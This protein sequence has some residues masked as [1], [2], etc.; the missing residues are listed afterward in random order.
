MKDWLGLLIVV[1]AVAFLAFLYGAAAGIYR[2]FPYSLISEPYSAFAQI[3]SR[4][5]EGQSATVHYLYEPRYEGEGVT[6][7]ES[8]AAYPGVTLLNSHW[9][10]NGAM[11][12]ADRLIDMD[13]TLINEW[14][15]DAQN[16]WPESPY[17]DLARI[18]TNCLQFWFC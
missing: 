15:I 14:Q 17:N 3:M 12:A 4:S 5:S 9:L 18:G 6:K 2:I 7:H 11:G 10:R 16:I 8:E 1:I 13:G